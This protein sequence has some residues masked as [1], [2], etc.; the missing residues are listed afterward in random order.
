MSNGH[1]Y[2][3]WPILEASGSVIAPATARSV[4]G[5]LPICLPPYDAA[6]CL[7]EPEAAERER[8]LDLVVLER[9]AINRSIIWLNAALASAEITQ[10]RELLPAA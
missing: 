6:R 10:A 1:P 9:S 8:G 3:G 4:P 2:R 7:S 5:C